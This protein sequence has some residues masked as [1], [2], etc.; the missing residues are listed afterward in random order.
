MCIHWLSE[1]EKKWG[2][3]NIAFNDNKSMHSP[4]F[5]ELEE[6]SQRI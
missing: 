6:S 2:A 3:T 4:L 1:K 5:D